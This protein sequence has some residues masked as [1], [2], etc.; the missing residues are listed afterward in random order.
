[1]GDGG[2]TT[3]ERTVVQK[4]AYSETH[5]WAFN[6]E[7][8]IFYRASEFTILRQVLS[9]QKSADG[10]F[11]ADWVPRE[12]LHAE[13]TGIAVAKASF[14]EGAERIVFLMTEIDKDNRAVGLPLVAK[15]SLWKQKQSGL[16]YLRRWHRT[17]VKTQMKAANLAVK[18]NQRLD[19][20]GVSK[21]VP[22]L[23]FL[24]CSVYE[25][26]PIPSSVTNAATALTEFVCLAEKRLNPECYVKWNNNAGDVD[27]IGRNND[28]QYEDLE[29]EAV[30]RKR[31]A[32]LGGIEEGDEEEED[33]EDD[34]DEHDVD[35]IGGVA[36]SELI[37]ITPKA[38]V[39]ELE[40]RV[41]EGDIPQAF[42]HFSY[43]W[44]KREEM[45]CDIQGELNVTQSPAIFELTDPCI[46]WCD[47]QNSVHTDKGWNRPYKRRQ[48]YG[49]TDKGYE[50][51][52]LF[53]MTHQ[54][55]AVCKLLGIHN[56]SYE[57]H[58]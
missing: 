1:M 30:Q 17:F 37:A 49:R 3:R 51:V 57:E 11:C 32:D 15:H 18:F 25:C 53:F 27:G 43:K 56:L 36:A 13:A 8:W 12:F 48:K 55:N 50:G 47:R 34:D 19:N 16:E 5:K 14:A 2:S 4:S 7:N 28:R 35:K 45:V 21:G 38:E 26:K 42:T 54:C 46:H 58:S 44:T 31:L 52:N 41:L 33:E 9:W 23:R 10:I 24:D 40:K 29:L 39:M 20:L 22:R 6:E